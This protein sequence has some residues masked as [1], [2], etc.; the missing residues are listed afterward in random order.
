MYGITRQRKPEA[1]TMLMFP[2]AVNGILV[3]TRA[4]D[5]NGPAARSPKKVGIPG[6]EFEGSAPRPAS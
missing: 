5:Q 1:T 6:L 4:A 3:G 2:D